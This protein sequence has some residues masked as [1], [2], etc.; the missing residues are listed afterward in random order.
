VTILAPRARA[1]FLNLG[2]HQRQS[3]SSCR[4]GEKDLGNSYERVRGELIVALRDASCGFV[5]LLCPTRQ[6]VCG[7]LSHAVS[8]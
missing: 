7:S 1:L 8:D 2:R 6:V 3:R 5:R 4:S